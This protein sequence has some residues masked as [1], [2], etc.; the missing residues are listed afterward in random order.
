MSNPRDLKINPG[1]QA[2]PQI[3]EAVGG[4]DVTITVVGDLEWAVIEFPNETPFSSTLYLIDKVNQTVATVQSGKGGDKAS[5]KEYIYDIYTRS[6]KCK[7]IT[8][9]RMRIRE[10]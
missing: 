8:P 1:C 5:E 9:P 6:G 3:L 2:K 10:N 4:D 7:F